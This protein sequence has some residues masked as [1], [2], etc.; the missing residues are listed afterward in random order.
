MFNKGLYFFSENVM[1]SVMLN[2]KG[3]KVFTVFEMF[4]T[5]MK[6]VVFVKKAA[7]A[8]QRLQS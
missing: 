8:R 5:F 2:I 3:L 1:L 7:Y 4:R 6:K